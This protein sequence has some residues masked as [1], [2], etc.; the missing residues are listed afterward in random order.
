M[1][2]IEKFMKQKL[3]RFDCKK[4]YCRIN[5]NPSVPYPTQNQQARYSR[6]ASSKLSRMSHKQNFKH[7]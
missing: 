1:T 7:S 5:K 4:V 2:A 3:D 6:E